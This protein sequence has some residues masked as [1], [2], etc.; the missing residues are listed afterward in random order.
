MPTTYPVLVPRRRDFGR[1]DE[2]WAH[3]KETHWADFNIIEGVHEETG[4]FNRSLAIN[5]AADLAGDWEYAI[6]A[7]ADSTVTHRQIEQGLYVAQLTKSLVI[8]HSRWVN[9][10]EDETEVYF[11]GKPLIWRKDRI[12]Y[13][14]TLSSVLIVPRWIWDAVNGFDER[15]VG[16]GWEDTAFMHAVDTMTSGHIRL[17]GDV[18]HFAHDRPVADT[19]RQ[20]DH[21]YI[22]NTNHYR[23]QYKRARSASELARVVARNRGKL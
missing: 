23:S 20:L 16:W 21:G 22:A 13:N 19:G 6:I 11:E 1:R 18:L 15:F 2:I 14:C 8:P 4:P 10:D 9:V 3:L 12:K 17:E 7:D 5:R